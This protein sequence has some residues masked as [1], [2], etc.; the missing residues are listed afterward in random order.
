MDIHAW[1]ANVA[2]RIYAKSL[3]VAERNRGRIPYTT[4][5]QGRFDDR[6]GED[7]TW[8]TN[9]FWAGMLWQLH[10]M[11]QCPL[12]R[13]IAQETES[14]LDGCF[15]S[16]A[17]MDHDGGFRWLTTAGADFKLTGNAASRNRLILAASAL[18]GRFNITGSFIR[19]WNDSGD[20]STAG[21]SIIDTLM[22][23]P[24]LYRASREL[25]DPR[26][27]KIATAHARMARRVFVRQDGSCAHI[28]RFDPETGELLESR[29]GQGMD[30]TSSWCRGQAWAL[31]GFTLSYLN[32]GDGAFLETARRVADYF[33]AHIPKGHL[34]P[35]DFCQDDEV[36]WEDSSAAA[37]A[38]CGLIELSRA[39]GDPRYQTAAV[40]LLVTLEERRCDFAPERDNLL[41]NCSESYHE[42]E[43]NI[44]LI[45]GDYFFTE[46]IL[47][48]AGRETRIWT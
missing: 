5:P 11:R 35:V 38:S 4:D 32:T 40:G 8:W 22:D 21:V 26:F 33:L 7:I 44:P 18:A 34:I 20:G 45:Y 25:K 36:P 2:E 47:K 1:A 43:H 31:Y 41:T 46:A 9:G 48:L 39:T 15:L 16:S 28:L 30:Y 29:R 42:G 14:K 6:G 37:I 19:A 13:T 3:I 10:G 23:L 17:G 12:F 24:L 27:R